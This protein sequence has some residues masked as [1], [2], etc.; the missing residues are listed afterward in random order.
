[1]NSEEAYSRVKVEVNGIHKRDGGL[2]PRP[3]V[4]IEVIGRT[5]TWKLEGIPVGKATTLE[6]R[7]MVEKAYDDLVSKPKKSEV[8]VIKD[9]HD[10][11]DPEEYAA[12]VGVIRK[13]L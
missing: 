1:M 2:L 11:E 9:Y 3:Y 5:K 13:R 8:V 10:D 7:K 12:R 6:I 4:V